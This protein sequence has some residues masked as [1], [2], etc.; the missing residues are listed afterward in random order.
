MQAD[1]R[2]KRERGK[3]GGR[4]GEEGRKR[5]R[6]EGRKWERER[7]RGRLKRLRCTLT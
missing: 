4:E 5:G 3:K 1:Q 6:D 2:R 7:G